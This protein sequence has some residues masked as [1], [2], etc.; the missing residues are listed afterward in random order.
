LAVEA[1]EVSGMPSVDM[2]MG[3]LTIPIWAAGAVSAVFVVAIVLAVGKA[4]AA[5][6][7][8]TLFRAAILLVAIYGGWLY[9]Q[10]STQESQAAD[11][12]ALD[13]RSAALM[14]R[15]IAPGSALSCLDEVGGDTVEAACEKAVFASPEAVAAA[16]NYVAAKLE[17]LVDG[18]Q[19]AQR[20]DPSF[21][22][23]LAPIRAALELD[24]FGIVAHVLAQRDG[25]TL[26]Q[27]DTLSWLQDGSQVLA[28][29]RDH[30]FDDQ[31]T[32]YTAV[33]TAAAHPAAE[34]HVLAA[35]AP[36]A[37]APTPT[38]SAATVAPRYDFPSSQSIPQV[39]IM[40]PESGAPRPAASGQ[41]AVPIDANAQAATP[42]PPRRPPQTRATTPRAAAA[43]PEPPPAGDPAGAGPGAPAPR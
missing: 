4:G 23:E 42:V 29:L 26:E 37:S 12:R 33:W 17:L 28:H 18:T 38:P 43:R 2:A 15:A 22:A 13:E 20:I 30:S 35:V 19:Y 5:T 16:V 8:A 24:R 9:M 41:A 7:I 32:K 39:N 11:R 25:C 27:C 3:T 10:R 14:A 34:T 31:V 36:A 6:L 40:A 1:N 21:A